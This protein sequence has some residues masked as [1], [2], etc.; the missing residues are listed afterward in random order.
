[1]IFDEVL[2]LYFTA[3]VKAGGLGITS[4]DFAKT[5]SFFGLIQLFIQFKVYPKLSQL[6]STLTLLRLACLLFVPVY[7]CFPELTTVR[8]WIDDGS[9][10]WTFRFC[11]LCLLFVRFFSSCLAFT[12]SAIMV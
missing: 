10:N 6:H 2:P 8:N 12:S 3:P 4:A 7:M 5:L 1:M 9:Q 11:F